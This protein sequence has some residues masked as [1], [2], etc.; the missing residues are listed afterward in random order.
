[1]ERKKAKYFVLCLQRKEVH[2]VAAAVQLQ[3][4]PSHPLADTCIHARVREK[5][6]GLT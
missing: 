6:M 5:P 4:L 2:A 3:P 1:M